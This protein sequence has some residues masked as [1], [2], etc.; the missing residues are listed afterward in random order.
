LRRG[1]GSRGQHLGKLLGPGV[2]DL[3]RQGI[4]KK[5]FEE[6]GSF[7]WRRRQAIDAIAIH[8]LQEH[9]ET[10]HSIHQ[11]PAGERGRLQQVVK[12]NVGANPQEDDDYRQ[13]AY[14][15]PEHADAKDFAGQ[16]W[17]AEKSEEHGAKDRSCAG[18]PRAT[19]ETR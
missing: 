11:L 19:R 2:F 9:A 5:A 16:K 3:E 8:G 1:T 4:G 12:K 17:E 15:T 18:A 10:F 14:R 6:R 13:S 7:V